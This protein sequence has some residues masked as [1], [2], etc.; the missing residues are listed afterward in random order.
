ME[1]RQLRYLIGIIDFGSFSKASAQLHVAQPALS[2]QIAHLEIELRS[3]LLIPEAAAASCGAI[4]P[5]V[6]EVSGVSTIA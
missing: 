6:T 3:I 4:S 1:L 5:V 2:Q